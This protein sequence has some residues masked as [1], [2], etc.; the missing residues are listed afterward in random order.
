MLTQRT[1]L[2]CI[3]VALRLWQG[4]VAGALYFG[5]S[6]IR[7]IESLRW[8]TLLLLVLA[9]PIY[10]FLSRNRAGGYYDTLTQQFTRLPTHFK[11]IMA[12]DKAP[13]A[14][15]IARERADNVWRFCNAIESLIVWLAIA[16]VGLIARDD[17]T[18]VSRGLETAAVF[19]VHVLISW[20]VFGGRCRGL[21][22]PERMW[23]LDPQSGLTPMLRHPVPSY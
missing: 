5:A 13:Y 4:G 14:E 18:W 22:Q 3:V 20:N 21:I 1:E 10:R 9:T 19:C 8:L 16:L 7:S 17:A 11:D 15:A 23:I 2:P 12:R 6:C